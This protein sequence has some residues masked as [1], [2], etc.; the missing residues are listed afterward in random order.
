MN[1]RTKRSSSSSL[2]ANKQFHRQ[3]DHVKNYLAGYQRSISSSKLA[4]HTED[5]YQTLI[6]RKKTNKQKQLSIQRQT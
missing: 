3:N 2:F 4:A 5:L 1:E 6:L